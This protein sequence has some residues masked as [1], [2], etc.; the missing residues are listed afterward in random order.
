MS[1]ENA[2]F[3]SHVLPSPQES[4]LSNRAVI[5]RNWALCGDAAAWVD[6]LTGEG[7]FYAMRS[8]ELL[9]ALWRKDPGKYIRRVSGLRFLPNWSLLRGSCGASIAVRS[10][11]RR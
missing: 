3:Y 4:T 1:T 9:G 6:P 7:L 5:G 11:D 10:E 8:G 2:K